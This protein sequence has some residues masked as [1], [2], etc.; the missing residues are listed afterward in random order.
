[1]KR[2]PRQLHLEDWSV[3]MPNAWEHLWSTKLFKSFKRFWGNGVGA[4]AASA[5][6]ASTRDA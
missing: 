3:C 2:T 5:R 4:T 1:M 6:E